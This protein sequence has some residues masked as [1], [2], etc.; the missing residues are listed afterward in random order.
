MLQDNDAPPSM[1]FKALNEESNQSYLSMNSYISSPQPKG[2]ASSLIGASGRN[3]GFEDEDAPRSN[4]ANGALKLREALEQQGRS[5]LPRGTT[6]ERRNRLAAQFDDGEEEDIQNDG[7]N[8]RMAPH[9]R[10]ANNSQMEESPQN[11]KG[12][13]AVTK[14]LND[15][16][17]SSTRTRTLNTVNSASSSDV[18]DEA[19]F[20][21]V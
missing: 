9:Q 6:F 12:G 8:S 18:D 21:H 20:E 1:I 4:R 3:V 13:A 16:F 7:G 14:S 5:K 15:R 19:D 10:S 11:G 2:G 17:K